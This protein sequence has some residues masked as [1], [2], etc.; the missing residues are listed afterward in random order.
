MKL[1]APKAFR[2]TTMREVLQYLQV[3][4]AKAFGDVFAVLG[5]LKLDE[6]YVEVVATSFTNFAASGSGGRADIQ[7]ITLDQGTWDVYASVVFNPNGAAGTLSANVR[8][9]VKSLDDATDSRL[10]QSYTRVQLGGGTSW[11]T[12]H[13]YRRLV[14]PARTPVYL[15]ASSTYTGGPVQHQGSIWAIGRG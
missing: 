12:G 6:R 4:A 2:G 7:K 5:K 8:I 9:S 15:V 14:L 11:Q 1:L 10:S 13:A 3:E